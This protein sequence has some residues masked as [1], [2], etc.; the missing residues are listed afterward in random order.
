MH[1]CCSWNRTTVPL[2]NRLLFMQFDGTR[3]HVHGCVLVEERPNDILRRYRIQLSQQSS[4]YCNRRGS[5][6]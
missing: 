5:I 4:L 6:G 2:S 1:Q 3:E